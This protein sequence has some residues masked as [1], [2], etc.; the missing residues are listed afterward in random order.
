MIGGTILVLPLIGIKTGYLFIPMVSILYGSISCYTCYLISYHLGECPN[1]RLCILE[2]FNNHHLATVVYN[3]VIGLSLLG[4]LINYFHL[5]ILQIQG[6]VQPSPLIP[7]ITFLA[8]LILTI[9]M[10]SL[11]F[12]EKLLAIGI[13]SIIG[14]CAFLIWAHAT[15]P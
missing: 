6:F 7:L 5:I 12:G 2:H 8:L 9:L 3:F 14:Y 1:I 4:F 11:N 13:V 15:T 10:R